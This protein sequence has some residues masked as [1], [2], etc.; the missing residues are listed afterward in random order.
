MSIDPQS[1]ALP[2]EFQEVRQA[3]PEGKEALDLYPALHRELDPGRVV[4]THIRRESRRGFRD[5]IVKEP[6]QQVHVV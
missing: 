4:L 1:A 5:L 3:R 2:D 6:T